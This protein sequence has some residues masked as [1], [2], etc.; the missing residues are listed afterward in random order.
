MRPSV[1]ELINP[2]PESSRFITRKRADHLV[3]RGYAAFVTDGRLRFLEEYELLLLQSE[4]SRKRGDEE[5]EREIEMQRGGK[6][7]G[8]WKPKACGSSL[9]GGPRLRTMQFVPTVK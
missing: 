6:L 3:R 2:A 8:E 1:V 9:P 5:Y 7:C 4:I